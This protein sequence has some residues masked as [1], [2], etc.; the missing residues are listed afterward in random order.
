MMQQYLRIK[1]GHPHTLVF[2]RMGDFYELFYEDAEKAA[3]LLGITL[4]QRGTSNGVP[5]RMAGVPVHSMEQYLARLLRSGESVAVCEQIGDPAASKGPVERKVVRVVTPGTVTDE[6]LLHDRD[7]NLLLAIAPNTRIGAQ[8][9]TSLGIAWLALASG[10]CWLAEIAP[11]TLAD[12]LALLR[13]AELIVPDGSADTLLA[14]VDASLHGPVSRSADWQFDTSRARERLCEALDVSSLA[15]FDVE[16]A[17]LAL[18]AAGALLDYVTRTQGQLPRHLQGVRLHL[19]TAHVGIDQAARRNLE[20]TE[21]L[22][23]PDAP[24]LLRT[25]DTCATGAGGRTMRRWLQAPLRSSAEITTRLDRVET[26]TH[27]AD[28]ALR[29][30]LRGQPDYERVATRI[31]L[32][33]VRPRELAALRDARAALRSIVTQIAEL[34]GDHFAALADALEPPVDAIAAL[35]AALMD[36]PSA[37]ARDGNVIRDGHDPDLDELRAIDAGCGDYLAALE[38]RERERTG[39]ATLRVGFNQ[40]HGFYIEVSR[41]QTERVPDEYRRRQTLKNAERYITPELKQ[42]EDKALSA[43]ERSLAREKALYEALVEAL[44]PSISRWQALGRAIAELDALAAFARHARLMGW[45]RPSFTTLP[46]IEIRGGRH[47]VVECSVE[48]FVPN[49]C[50]MHAQRRL[51]LLTGPNMGGKST[52]MRS[53]ALITVLAFCGSFVPAERC[54]LGPVDRIFT[55]IG[56]SDDLA[57]G[58]STFMVEMTEA[59]AILHA[60]T[61]HSLVL[62]DEI[63]RGTSTFDG[64]A[65]AHAIAERLLTRNRA[66]CLF[67]THY[68]ELTAIAA[69]DPHAVNLHLAAT[70]HRGRVVFLHEVRDGP[71]SRSYGIQVAR[72][73]GIPQAVV[74]AAGNILQQLEARSRQDADQFDLFGGDAAPLDEPPDEPSMPP[75]SAQA[76]LDALHA[77]DLDGL[78]PRDA[79]QSLYRLRAMLDQANPGPDHDG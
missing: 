6:Q 51:V 9:G 69:R 28:D 72:L 67:A 70:E 22:A 34:P 1:A 16:S 15:A 17:P 78:S 61:E 79:L 66:L 33:S 71:A 48:R 39:I 23:G 37:L 7:D 40:V 25:L 74:R 75:Q 38:I 56:A 10:E 59:A 21:G 19:D 77:L 42:F 18:A 11:E 52:Y 55:R 49:D 32:G 57:G 35:E 24:S 3:N 73:A 36:E 53:V 29:P 63:G 5:V 27:G 47:P 30:L 26:L 50:L 60:A 62:M 2:Y 14:D 65:L 12:R 31:A 8:S 44:R 45:I 13:P 46:G 54:V 76:V 58:R 4:T 68:F 41:G 43:K 64:L 20:I